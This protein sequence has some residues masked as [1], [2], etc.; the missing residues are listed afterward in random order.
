MP[1]RTRYHTAVQRVGRRDLHRQR[2][3]VPPAALPDRLQ[4]GPA[5]PRQGP[6]LA[7]AVAPA[8][9]DQLPVAPDRQPGVAVAV[10]EAE[11]LAVAARVDR[12]GEAESPDR[13]RGQLAPCQGDPEAH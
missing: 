6:A 3:A 7:P 9:E 12:P 5:G 10:E 1:C 11:L 8:R 13:L 2:V 4:P